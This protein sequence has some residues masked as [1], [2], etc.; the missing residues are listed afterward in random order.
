MLPEPL[1]Q[2]NESANLLEHGLEQHV[3]LVIVSSNGDA[4]PFVVIGHGVREARQI[5]VVGDLG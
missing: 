5:G 2:Y 4:D 1:R 3:E